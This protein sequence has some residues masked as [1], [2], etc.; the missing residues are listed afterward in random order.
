EFRVGLLI[1]AAPFALATRLMQ[2]LAWGTLIRGYGDKLPSYPELTLVY[3]KSWLGRYVP[4]KVAWVGG[5]VLFGS[6]YGIRSVVLA[7]TSVIEAGIQTI[8]A[9]ALAL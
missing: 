4:G 9:L 3:A 1:L 8:T 7:A 5:K 6:K 2:P